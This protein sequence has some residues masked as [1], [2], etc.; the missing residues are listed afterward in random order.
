MN[1][2]YPL[3]PLSSGNAAAQEASIYDQYEQRCEQLFAYADTTN[4]PGYLVAAAKLSRKTDVKTGQKMLETLL[5]DPTA[6][7]RGMFVIYELMAAYLYGID[8][9]PP[10]L[11]HRIWK[12]FRIR[13]L[14]RGDTENH[15]VM[16]Y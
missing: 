7:G 14:Y 1:S 8:E 15:W 12:S 10:E 16:Y 13:P 4:E 3:T 9:I 5:V 11:K 2:I 6:S